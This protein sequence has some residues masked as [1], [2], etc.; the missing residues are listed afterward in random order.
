MVSK[1]KGAY[2]CAVQSYVGLK[3]PQ[4]NRLL[5]YGKTVFEPFLSGIN[6][7]PFSFETEHIFAER[8]VKALRPD[9]VSAMIEQAKIGRLNDLA[10]LSPKQMGEPFS[11][12]SSS[13]F[14]PLVSNCFISGETRHSIET[15][16]GFPQ[17][18]NWEMKSA[19]VPFDSLDELL[20][21]CGLPAL[22]SMA[23][24]TRL[25]MVAKTPGQID[26]RS[27]ITDSKGAI[28]SRVAK[29]LDVRKLKMGVRAFAKNR[30]IIR[31]SIKGSQFEWREER[32]YMVGKCEVQAGDAPVLEAYLSYDGVPL[33][34]SSVSDP[35][36]HLNPR[37]AIHRLFDPGNDRL[38]WMLL[39][40]QKD[41]AQV[42]E[43]AVS[44]LLTLIGFSVTNYG[45]F[46]KLQ[47]GPDIIAITPS[48]GVA[49][50]E[51]TIGLLS[52]NDKL[53]KLV[54]RTQSIREKLAS[55]GY[56]DME[57]QPVSMTL[58]SRGEVAANLEDAGANGIA[59][60]CKEN[61]E[62]ALKLIELPLDANRF[63]KDLKKLIPPS[64][65]ESPFEL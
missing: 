5:L 1:W 38:P 20:A 42:F 64:K 29:T 62:D 21:H 60:V 39:D 6:Q 4:G 43:G 19:D 37:F 26:G 16:A 48:G 14:H 63:F 35:T 49:I 10:A 65:D 24:D 50:V 58:L 53:S 25:E 52:Q 15:Q 32:D 7:T 45:R 9:D 30:D 12:Y 34:Q 44:T 3:T 2:V 27:T 8:F 36:K 31:A 46:P 47:E 11:D 56:S 13:N 54:Q 28:E 18:L 61:L 22:D 59:V 40:A 17:Y 51:C 57:I 33:D 41:K 55:A 23:G